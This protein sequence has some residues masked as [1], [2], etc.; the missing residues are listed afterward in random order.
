MSSS[1]YLYLSLKDRDDTI[2][3]FHYTTTTSHQKLFKDLRVDLYSSVEWSPQ[4]HLISYSP[5]L[6]DIGL[7]DV[8]SVV[9]LVSQVSQSSQSVKSVRLGQPLRLGQPVRLRQSVRLDQ[10]IRLYCLSVSKT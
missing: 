8:N 1:L 7:R 6:S 4:V 2:I 10:S 5:L 9:D 3:T